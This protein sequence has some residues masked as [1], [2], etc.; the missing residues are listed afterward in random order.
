MP[1]NHPSSTILAPKLTPSVLGQLVA[2]YEHTVFVEGV[3]WG[4]D[5]FDQWGVELGK[6]MATELAPALSSIEPKDSGDKDESTVALVDYFR[7]QKEPTMTDKPAAFVLFGITGDLAQQ[8]ARAGAVPARSARR[9]RHPD[10]R[11]GTHRSRPGRSD[12]Q[13]A[14]ASS[15]SPTTSTR[16]SSLAFPSGSAWSLATI[17][18][19]RPSRRYGPSSVRRANCVHYLAVPPSLFATVAAG[20][21]AVGLND[22]ARLVVEKPFGH[23]L[24]SAVALNA[25]LQKYFPEEQIFRV[26]HFLGKEPVE[27]LLMFRFANSILE[28]LWNRAHVASVQITMAEDFDVSDRGAFYDS[29]GAIRDVLEN[30]LLQLLTYLAMDPPVADSADALRDEQVRLLKSVRAIVPDELVRGQYDG[31]LDVPGVRKGST[32]ETYAAVRL[33]IDN[34]RWADVPF[35]IRTG[36]VL[37]IT[38]IEVVVE[39]RR[40]PQLLFASPSGERPQPNL[41]RFHLQPQAALT[42]ELLAKAPGAKDATKQILVTVD[43]SRALGPEQEAYE[44]VVADAL[45]GDPRHFAREDMVEEEW[46]IVNDILD[47]K[48]APITYKRDTW[49]PKEAE[50]LVPGGWVGVKNAPVID[51]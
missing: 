14:R 7:S 1:G 28:P 38:V 34:W 12:R 25:E 40:P 42:F 43:L 29:V 49:G 20:I 46:R 17:R 3:V 36:K 39:L 24:A 18:R 10:R 50:E 41:I 15:P 23:D 21:A 37:P 47:R 33:H 26:D 51:S 30:H 48:E 45:A 2:L 44:R 8:A 9:P 5:S 4:I 32:T 31:Y 16:R 6:E 35:V 27:D 22:G 13:A 19:R 11:S